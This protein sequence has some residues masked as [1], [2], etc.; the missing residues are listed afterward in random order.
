MAP[1]GR[2]ATIDVAKGMGILLVVLGHNIAIADTGLQRVLGSFRMPLFLFMAGLFLAPGIV[3]YLA[4]RV[5]SLLQPFFV[6]GLGIATLFWLKSALLADHGAAVLGSIAASKAAG[7]LYAVGTTLDNIPL[8]FL[9]A[10]FM[11]QLVALAFVGSGVLRWP[12]LAAAVLLGMM[13]AGLWIMRLNA[14]PFDI[15]AGPVQL[16]NVIGLPWSVDLALLAG[17]FVAAGHA[18]RPLVLGFRPAAVPL[19]LCAAIFATLHLWSGIDPAPGFQ[20]FLDLNIR[21]SA[22]IPTVLALSLTGIYLALVV[23]W[24]VARAPGPA[25]GVLS[26]CGRASLFILLFHALPQQEAYHA[27]RGAIGSPAAASILS[28]GV[29]LAVPL[30]LLA[31]TRR[32]GL[33][34]RLLLPAAGRRVPP[35]RLTARQSSLTHI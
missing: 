16:R 28:F 21:R 14:A 4:T 13:A 10:L 23:A 12:I 19:I 25:A 26:A 3:P 6:V 30:A 29:G 9:P 22:D 18:C 11:A 7:P 33:F 20:T 31:L 2:D 32:V 24:I 17:A 1:S 34:R 27:I 8:W 15:S 35:P 5:R